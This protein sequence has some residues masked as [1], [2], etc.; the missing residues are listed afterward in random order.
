MSTLATLIHRYS[1]ATDIV[2]GT[3]VAN[4]SF[5]EIEPLIGLFINTV[6]FR[7]DL[8]GDPAFKDF[9]ARVRS[10]AME[11]FNNQ[12]VPFESVLN[13]LLIRREKDRS[14]LFQVMVAMQPP[15]AASMSSEIGVDPAVLTPR[16]SKFD[17]TLVLWESEDGDVGGIIEYATDLFEPDTIEQLFKHFVTLLEGITS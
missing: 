12:D 10:D 16:G 9:L 4:R 7:F 11:V 2:I 3:P 8:S 1:G 6:A 15:R 17:M 14:P 13:D 5:R